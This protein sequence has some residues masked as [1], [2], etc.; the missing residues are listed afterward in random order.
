[1]FFECLYSRKNGVSSEAILHKILPNY[2][3]N[4]FSYFERALLK[5]YKLDNFF[6][7][8]LKLIKYQPIPNLMK[9]PPL[10][11]MHFRPENNDPKWTGINCL[12]QFWEIVCPFLE[13]F[14]IFFLLIFD[15]FL[16]QFSTI[17]SP[18]EQFLLYLSQFLDLLILI[19]I[20]GDLDFIF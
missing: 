3:G 20:P 12:G 9:I 4:I 10:T 19:L 18:F 15:P 13:Y 1:M 2:H 7:Y 14:Q 6:F 16:T 8:L 5:K 11:G 17:L